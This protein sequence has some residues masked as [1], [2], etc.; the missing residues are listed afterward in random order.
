MVN[1]NMPT[2]KIS[3]DFDL[4]YSDP[5]PDGH[6][7]VI[8]LHG[9]GATS[10]SWGYQIPTI[11]NQ[12]FR[13][14][15]PD[16]RGF[17]KSPYTGVDHSITDMASDIIEMMNR[18]CIDTAHLVGISMGGAV[19]LQLACDHNSRFEKL[20]LVNTFARL[21][22]NSIQGWFY[23][24]IR[25]VMIHIL[26]LPTQ[27]RFVASRLFPNP[28]QEHL[29]Q[30]FI[31]QVLQSDPP[32]YRATMRALMHFN[33]E[34]QVSNITNDTLV[35][36]GAKDFTVPLTAQQYLADQIPYVRHIIIDEAGHAA[37]VEKPVQVNQI[38]VEFLSN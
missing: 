20:V 5:A 36:T 24:A 28:D 13:I 14:L 34:S 4:F 10:E 2:L 30:T 33:L 23:F 9:L 17:G 37:T 31:E 38:L 21:R 8:L 27:A 25:L 29:R 15:V 19:A 16:M 7:C 3:S 18:E 12:G 22:P 35:I 6:P 11:L 32:G 1:A 26:G